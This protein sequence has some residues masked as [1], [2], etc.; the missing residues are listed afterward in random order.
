MKIKVADEDEAKYLAKVL[1]YLGFPFQYDV[2]MGVNE[3]TIPGVQTREDCDWES[4][5][6]ELGSDGIE[7]EFEVVPLLLRRR[8]PGRGRTQRRTV[9]VY[10]FE[11]DGH[12]PQVRWDQVFSAGWWYC[13]VED[14]E[15]SFPR[16]P[17][18]TKGEA[19]L[20]PLRGVAKALDVELDTTP[21]RSDD[22]EDRAESRYGDD[23]GSST[24]PEY[25]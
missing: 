18:P 8:T 6:E 19:R 13:I 3:F 4:I 14:G 22:A 5:L 16:G 17:H 23:C 10:T 7:L 24:P 1:V 25:Q 11:S 20:A 12:T 2:N 9:T 15:F 21:P